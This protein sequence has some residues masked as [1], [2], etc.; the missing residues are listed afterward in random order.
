MIT[1][2]ELRK[3]DA[4][5]VDF[6]SRISDFRS[7][8]QSLLTPAGK[9]SRDRQRKERAIVAVKREAVVGLL[10]K[11][12]STQEEEEQSRQRVEVA[13]A[14]ARADFKNALRIDRHKAGGDRHV[15]GEQALAQ[16]DPRRAPVIRRAVEEHGRRQHEAEPA[17]QLAE[18]RTVQAVQPEIRGQA[19]QHDVAEREARK[20]ELQPQTARRLAVA[21]GLQVGELQLRLVAQGRQQPD[22]FT[23][24]DLLVLEGDGDF[25]AREINLGLAD[26]GLEAEEVFE[27]PH[28][29]NAMDGRDVKR[30]AREPLVGKVHQ[31]FAHRRLIEE[32][33]LVHLRRGFD[34]DAS[35]LAQRVVIPQPILGKQLED[36]PATLAAEGFLSQCE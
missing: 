24:P 35:S 15:D 12:F 9:N 36:G 28:A 14:P 22:E 23:E 17:H 4:F 5:F 33:E 7:G 1:N 2:G 20:P 26:A 30:H 3:G 29:G 27:Q 19:E 11:Q 34:A 18:T 13:F 10:L 8:S 25:L 6:G 21:R 31:P 16:T 32:L